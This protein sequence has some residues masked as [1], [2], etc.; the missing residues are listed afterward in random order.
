[1]FDAILCIAWIDTAYVNRIDHQVK[2]S[3]VSQ[4]A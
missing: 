2:K 4:G 3:H 1:M